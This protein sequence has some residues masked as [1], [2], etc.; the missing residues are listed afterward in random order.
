MIYSLADR[1]AKPFSIGG[2]HKAHKDRRDMFPEVVRA[3]REL[4]PRGILVENVKGLKRKT[5]T[6]YF[7]YIVLQLSHPE[8]I[9]G[10]EERLD[11]ASKPLGAVPFKG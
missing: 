10:D 6:N 4:R 7:S 11:R 3:V 1:R 8:V 5:F 9:R 2:K